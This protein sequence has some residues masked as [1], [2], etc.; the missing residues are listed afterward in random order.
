MM[1]IS[2]I[3]SRILNKLDTFDSKID[4]LCERMV[5]IET[6]VSNHLE[7]QQQKFNRTTVIFGLLIASVGI[8]VALK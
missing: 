7:H 5:R 1:V 3:E 2:D 8:M 6:T 4:D